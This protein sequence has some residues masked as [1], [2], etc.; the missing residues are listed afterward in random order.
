MSNYGSERNMSFDN[1]ISKCKNSE[2]LDRLKD[3][4]KVD[5]YT[6]ILHLYIQQFYS[7]DLRSSFMSREEYA[8]LSLL[9]S[10]LRTTF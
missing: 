5:L 10:Q 4:K 7:I 9:K 1:E 2:E 8:F 3:T 6:F